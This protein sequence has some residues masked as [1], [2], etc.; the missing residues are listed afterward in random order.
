MAGVQCLKTAAGEMWLTWLVPNDPGPTQWLQN[1]DEEGAEH[2]KERFIPLMEKFPI[3]HSF[4]RPSRHDKTDTFI[5]FKHMWMR[6]E[7]VDNKAN[8]QRKSVK[9]QMRSEGW[10]KQYWKPGRLKEAMSRQTQFAYSSKGY[11]ESQPGWVIRDDNG[12]I[13]GDDLY[14]HYM[15]GTQQ[16]WHFHCLGCGRPQPYYWTFDREDGTRAGMI[17]ETSPKTRRVLPDGSLGQWRWG[18]LAPTIRYECIFCGHGHTDDVLTR[19]RLTENSHYIALNP[20]K[21]VISNQSGEVISEET[22]R[23]GIIDWDPDYDFAPHESFNWNQL[24]M[25]TLNWFETK[26]GGVKNYLIAKEQA[27]KGYWL[28]L[29]EFMQKV[30][31][32]PVDLAKRRL[33]PR[34]PTIEIS[35]LQVEENAIV[36]NGIRFTHV[37]MAVDVQEDH[38]WYLVLA[39]SADGKFL[40]LDFGKAYSWGQIEAKQTEHKVLDQN[41]S[42]DCRHRQ[43]E[44]YF[45]CTAHGHWETIENNKYWMCWKA[46]RGSDERTFSYTVK[47][48][49]ERGRRISLPYTWPP[50]MADPCIGLSA[51]DER[52]KRVV[53]RYCPVITW[54]NPTIKDTAKV[55]RDSIAKKTR[56]FMKPGDWNDECSE[57]LFSEKKIPVRN[58]LG[59]VDWKWMVIGKK[60]NHGWDDFCMIVNRAIM[61]RLLGQATDSSTEGSEGSKEETDQPEPA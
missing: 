41:V 18:E 58:K 23:R 1:T 14:V 5:R 34:L 17:W 36:Y 43:N 60:P 51:Q 19:R 35:T 47:K 48:G 10:Q 50:Q 24:G 13:I 33:H 46:L 39:F 38:F 7:G 28:P 42:V 55:L 21:E 44:V 40:I 3:V 16:T 53:G 2:A 26:I 20:H 9:N 11:T 32:Q 15:T 12:E 59:H 31:A 27:D 22:A 4:Y 57:H 45:E 54:S 25:P 49:R 52:R 37:F 61:M 8:L 30:V 6:I 56:G 29:E